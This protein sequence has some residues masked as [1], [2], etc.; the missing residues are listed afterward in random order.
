MYP[1]LERWTAHLLPDTTDAI[2]P[3]PDEICDCREVCPLRV[4]DEAHEWVFDR[5]LPGLTDD[6]LDDVTYLLQG[7]AMAL[8]VLGGPVEGCRR[9]G[10]PVHAHAALDARAP[11]GAAGQRGAAGLRGAP[12]LRL[13]GCRQAWAAVAWAFL[14]EA[15][16]R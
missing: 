10:G 4:W 8:R 12:G 5:D 13:W 11:G 15:L 2:C 7:I 16:S 14:R 6:A 1:R 9:H 3:C